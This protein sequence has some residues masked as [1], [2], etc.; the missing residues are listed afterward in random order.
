MAW[1]RAGGR[2]GKACLVPGWAT[3]SSCGFGTGTPASR[4]ALLSPPAQGGAAHRCVPDGFE[5]LPPQAAARTCSGAFSRALQGVE[6]SDGGDPLWV[7]RVVARQHEVAAVA[8]A[9]RISG[10]DL[11]PRQTCSGCVPRRRCGGETRPSSR[12]RAH[13]HSTRSTTLPG[14]EHAPE[15]AFSARMPDV[16][17]RLS[18]PRPALWQP[19]GPCGCSDAPTLLPH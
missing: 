8:A 11:P 18:P 6:G 16:D 15:L 17:S 12:R 5:L 2:A 4:Q 13:T 14:D 19:A 9:V 1:R 7:Q 3:C 10:G